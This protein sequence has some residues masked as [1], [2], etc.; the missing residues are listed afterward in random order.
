MF[1]KL[2]L[3]ADNDRDFL[4]TR[5]EYL[6][7]EGY[8]VI[9]AYSLAQARQ[10]LGHT[11]IHVAILDIRLVDDDDER[12]TSGL[13]LAK[14]PAF[15]AVPKII[16]TGFPTYQAVRE[17]LGLAAGNLPPAVNFLAKQEGPEAMLQAVAEAFTRDVRI[18]WNLRVRF[19]D[20][21][22]FLYLVNLI[23]PELD[24][25]YLGERTGILDDL[26]RRLFFESSE[27][28]FKR[29]L[30]RREGK[31]FLSAFAYPKIGVAKQF[32]VACGQ[33]QLILQEDANYDKFV[34]TASSQGMTIK[35]RTVE[36]I[37]YA[38]TRYI[39]IGGDLEEMTPF[40]EFYR[41]RSIET[42]LSMLDHLFRLTLAPWYKRERFEASDNNLHE[43]CRE[44]PTH[45]TQ[46]FTSTGL[47]QQIQHLC[48]E[49]LASGLAKIDYSPTGLTFRWAD[50]SFYNPLP[51]FVE[52]QIEFNEPVLCGITHGRLNGETI[53]AD[54]GG[55]TWVVDFSQVGQAPFI[56]DFA[57][58][59][60]AVKFE[61]LADFDLE[62]LLEVEQLL[63]VLPRLTEEADPEGLEP[64]LQKALASICRVRQL[65]SEVLGPSEQACRA[66]RIGLLHWTIA[67][68]AGFDLELRYTRKQ[69]VP[70]LYSLLS[71]AMLVQKLTPQPRPVLA[72]RARES[73]W[74]D[75]ANKQVWVEGRQVAL[76]PQQFKLLLYLYENQNQLCG[77]GEIAEEVF[78]ATYGAGL[79]K[80]EK[81]RME[82]G[83]IN[84]T[85]SRLRKRL[86]P[87]PGNPRYIVTVRGEGYRLELSG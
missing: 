29:L 67:Y 61:L 47:G 25:L 78:E 59:E 7:D 52:K 30:V 63:L 58:L 1:E 84:S 83:R 80:V 33:K 43:L 34:S 9:R 44:W 20:Q 18:N 42:I 16:L 35:D 53:L 32:V 23:E 46:I 26:F 17:V 28:Y 86:E 79:S 50:S 51:E 64:E 4:N 74:I 15:Q 27:V 76:T 82:E 45:L 62:D 11:R 72:S 40:S 57:S 81:R 77:Y 87:D 38:A 31:V 5:A 22:S 3:L 48:R 37:S 24:N 69:L 71:A 66:Y 49:A 6:E 2:V 85:I 36:T 12:D 21:L 13:T 10:L 39:L 8:R 56:C 70:Y 75:E 55:R 41:Y 54:Q 73:I 14:E 65:A 19:D 68:L 60:A